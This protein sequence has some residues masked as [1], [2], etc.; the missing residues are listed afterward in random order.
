MDREAYEVYLCPVHRDEQAT[1]PDRCSVCDREMVKRVLVPSYS[2]PMHPSIDELE[3]GACP[4][5]NMALVPTTRELQW[6]C[7]DAPETVSNEPRECPDGA[8]ME[9]RS[10]PMAHGDHNPK[11]GGVLFMAPDGYHHLEGTLD[12]DGTFRLYFY[13]DFTKPIDA[14]P[15][16][17]RIGTTELSPE[18]GGAYLTASVPPPAS[19]PAEVAVEVGFPGTHENTARF[20][21]VFVGD[22]AIA[23]VT[24]P[25]FRIPETADAIFEAILARDARLKELIR[26]G[27]WPDLY[28]PA[29]EAK[30][31]VLA[32]TEKEKARERVA[33]PAKKL[34]R[35]SWL[36]DTYGDMGNREQVE[37]AYRLFAEAVRELEDARAN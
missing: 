30:D 15:F 19:Y 12:E 32:L 3:E 33:L 7:P 24:L 28:I 14:T 16:E 8:Q 34:V 13:N 37:V 23:D 22:R 11:H 9:V 18:S 1:T 2:C 27:S 36:L 29:L 20:D 26:E 6:F 10:L 4:L 31:L 25:E 17:A 21:F 5:C 35:A